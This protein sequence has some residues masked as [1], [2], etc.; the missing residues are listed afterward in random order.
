MAEPVYKKITEL[1]LL[2][3]ALDGNETLPIVKSGKTYRRLW[4]N[5]FGSGWITSLLAAFSAFKAPDSDH[6]DDADTVGGEDK[7]TLH[8]ANNLTGVVPLGVIPAELT[9]KNAATAT[10]LATARTIGGVSFDGS[11][12]INLPGVNTAGNQNTSG[13][14]ATAGSADTAAVAGSC[15]GNAAT[16]TLAATATNALACSGNAATATTAAACSG[17]SATATTA[18]SCSGNAATATSAT[19]A[20]N[21]T[22][23]NLASRPVNGNQFLAA[24]TTDS[25]GNQQLKRGPR[26]NANS[27][28][29]NTWYWFGRSGEAASITLQPVPS[30]SAAGGTKGQISA[31]S[32]YLYICIAT[33]TWRRVSISGW[34]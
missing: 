18:A 17:N 10:K 33:N 1:D 2:S 3:T 21:A 28:D 22:N 34:S 23:V 11:A 32:S 24:F 15:S 30:S 20:T 5:F 19:N 7:A 4:A 12:N 13:K 26:V 9:G 8:T 27:A 6:A 16:A 31:D 29:E 14:A 25:D